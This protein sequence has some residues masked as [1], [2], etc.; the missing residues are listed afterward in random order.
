MPYSLDAII[1]VV[2]PAKKGK[3]GVTTVDQTIAAAKKQFETKNVFY[4]DNAKGTS[5]QQSHKLVSAESMQMSEQSRQQA[6]MGVDPD[7][8]LGDPMQV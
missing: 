2:K 8:P 7:E 4:E 1:N 6:I 5:G 3:A